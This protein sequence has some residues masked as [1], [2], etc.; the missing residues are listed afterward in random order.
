LLKQ[1][2]RFS[3]RWH[4]QYIDRVLYDE[5]NRSVYISRLDRMELLI[6]SLRSRV[7]E[8]LSMPSL[9]REVGVA[10]PTVRS[11]LEVLEK[12]YLIFSVTPWHR[13]VARGLK[14]ALKW[15]FLDWCFAGERNRVEGVVASCL[16]RWCS[17]ANDLCLGNYRLHY[18]RTLDKRGLKFI[19]ANEGRPTLAVDV[20]ENR[21][22]VGRALRD[23]ALWFRGRSFPGIQVVEAPGWEKDIGA[24]TWILG[25]DRFLQMFG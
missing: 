1:D 5:I 10:H 18:L 8:P 20:A 13:G 25:L 16:H 21:E 24:D 6:S 4:N 11:W 15:Y 22:K 14:K 17:M 2:E 7:G 3:N 23:R 19:V 9:G 12:F